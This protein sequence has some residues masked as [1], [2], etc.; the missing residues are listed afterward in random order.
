MN[1]HPLIND[2][3]SCNSNQCSYSEAIMSMFESCGISIDYIKTRK[4]SITNRFI[5]NMS[6]H[7]VPSVEFDTKYL[8]ENVLLPESGNFVGTSVNTR[9][10]F[11]ELDLEIQMLTSPSQCTR[12]HTLFEKNTI[13]EHC[14]GKLLQQRGLR[15]VI[16][17]F[18]WSGLDIMD[19]NV[20]LGLIEAD[21][22]VKF[23]VLINL[24]ICGFASTDYNQFWIVTLDD[25]ISVY[26]YTRK[27][28][29]CTSLFDIYSCYLQESS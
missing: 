9:Q 17:E 25:T 27:W 22:L 21:E 7:D 11:L 20:L 15:R 10:L 14:A 8:T 5:Q 24:E 2:F 19:V 28:V 4:L 3:I 13:H 29:Q 16:T 26:C 1:D 12:A 23:K 18:I 6:L